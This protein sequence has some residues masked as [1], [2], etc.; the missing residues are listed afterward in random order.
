MNSI[1][2]YLMDQ[3]L[4][5]WIVA[6]LKTHLGQDIFAG[7]YGIIGQRCSVLLALWLACWWMYR[8]QIFL[9]I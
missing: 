2:I 3:L 5:G 8:R 6:T 9:R 7:T 1:T 4:P